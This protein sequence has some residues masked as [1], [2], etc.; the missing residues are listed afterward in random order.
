MYTLKSLLFLLFLQ[1]YVFA[2]KADV[3]DII[4]KNFQSVGNVTT[5]TGDV[6]IKKGNDLLYSDKVVVFTDNN[7]KPFSY[8]A[9]GNVK[10]T[11]ITTDKRELKGS[12]NRLVYDVKKNQYTLYDNAIIQETGKANLL[13][14]D[15]IVLSADGEYANIVGKTTKPARVI[16]SLETTE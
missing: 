2:A 7:R 4:A 15:E 6:R 5:I 12:G 16:F 10:F 1:Q 11:I 13:K 8:E 3:I 14:G 9:T